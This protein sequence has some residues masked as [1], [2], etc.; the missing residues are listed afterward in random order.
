MHPFYHTEDKKSLGVRKTQEKP[1]TPV[2]PFDKTHTG[3]ELYP[4]PLG[5][6]STDRSTPQKEALCL[7]S[8]L[9]FMRHV[10]SG[11][12]AKEA[13]EENHGCKVERC[14]QRIRFV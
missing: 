2:R 10:P 9:R 3:E 7:R 6:S 5:D 8:S 12:E 11:P 1:V 14:L 4:C 13:D